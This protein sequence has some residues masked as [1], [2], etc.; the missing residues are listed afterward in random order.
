[1]RIDSKDGMGNKELYARTDTCIHRIRNRT[2]QKLQI[3]YRQNRQAKKANQKTQNIATSDNHNSTEMRDPGDRKRSRANKKSADKGNYTGM[4]LSEIQK[5]AIRTKKHHTQK[6]KW[7][8]NRRETWKDRKMDRIHR[9]EIPSTGKHRKTDTYAHNN[10]N[11]VKKNLPE[12]HR[13]EDPIHQQLKTLRQESALS[14]TLGGHP[15]IAKWPTRTTRPERNHQNA[16]HPFKQKQSGKTEYRENA[17]I[18]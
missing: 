12:H 1:M 13:K 10:G 15:Q 11:L 16:S 18:T 4:E 8:T 5:T 3:Y 9:R 17:P 7:G 2:K 6:T 14:Q